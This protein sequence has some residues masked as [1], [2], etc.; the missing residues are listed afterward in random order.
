MQKNPT[1][2]SCFFSPLP[3]CREFAKERERV[4]N[5]QIFLK[6]RRQQQLERE[7][8]GYVDWICRAEEVIL[9]EERT[10]EEER[11]HI[12]EARKR[13]ANK[14]RKMKLRMQ[15]RGGGLSAAAAAAAAAKGNRGKMGRRSRSTDDDDDDDD[16]EEDEE[17]EEEQRPEGERAHF[18]LFQGLYE[19]VKIPISVAGAVPQGASAIRNR[20]RTQGGCQQFWRCEKRVRFVAR[21]MH[22]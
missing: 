21:G 6:L 4:E 5:R 18:S 9:A 3:L 14:R 17:E 8:N 12:M 20:L 15:Q 16:E 2:Q 7:L 22:A 11:N 1:L 19:I 13:A 10:T